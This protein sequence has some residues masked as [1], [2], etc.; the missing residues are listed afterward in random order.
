MSKFQNT[1]IT[2]LIIN[3]GEISS[4]ALCCFIKSDSKH[5]IFYLSSSLTSEALEAISKILQ[6]WVSTYDSF[7]SKAFLIC[8]SWSVQPDVYYSKATLSFTTKILTLRDREVVGK[9][10][11][12]L[13][14]VYLCL[15]KNE[16]AI[17]FVVQIIGILLT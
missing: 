13:S 17:V 5:I 14:V 11:K 16:I 10:L 7:A 9:S 8:F 4:S 6:P 12:I 3:Y 15:G 2:I 1:S